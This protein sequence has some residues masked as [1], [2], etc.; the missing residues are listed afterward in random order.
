MSATL[1]VTALASAGAQ[2]TR[3][4]PLYEIGGSA[5][6]LLRLRQLSDTAA[7]RNILLRSTSRMTAGADTVRS[8]AVVFLLPELRVVSNSALPYGPNDGSL[9]AS[10]GLSAMLSVGAD[11]RLGRLRLVLAPEVVAE[12]NTPYQTI[13]YPLNATPPRSSWANPFHPLP[14]SI[15]LPLRFGDSEHRRLTPGQ[16]SASLDL[17]AVTAGVATE[18]HWW[19]PGIRTAI[20]LSN[21]AA[22]FPHAFVR[23]RVPLATGFG[24]L[25]FDVIAGQVRE[26]EYFD[27]A[28]S[29]DTRTLSGLA[30]TWRPSGP[31]GLQLGGA[32]LRLDGAEGHDQMSSLFGR[33]VF[34]AAGVETYA[35]WA[36]FQDPRSLRDFLELPNHSQG[37]TLGLQWRRDLRHARVLRLHAE[38]SYLEPSTTF[39]IRPVTTSYTSAKVPQGFTH[40]GEVL[41]AAIGPGSS[42][43]WVA[44]DVFSGAR[45]IGLFAARIRYDNATMLGPLVPELR[46]QDVTMLAGV[47]AT[48]QLGGLHILAEFTDAV[49]LNYLFQGYIDDPILGTSKGVDIT[50]RTLAVTLSS[51][52]RIPR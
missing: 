21:N 26:S 14:E 37:Y 48:A 5:D 18:N 46:R 51:A 42:S 8:R 22:G 38:V 49:R 12:Q 34:P 6:E 9:R 7:T 35:E 47:R 20:V 2:D 4:A 23:P 44:A 45:R 11:L 29:N 33:W 39:R 3:S 41:G 15:D 28:D 32:R 27:T 43:Q 50:N 1:V 19:G 52:P 17:G 40:R 13:P 30:F 16:S 36:R 31:P 24:V 10:R 25:D